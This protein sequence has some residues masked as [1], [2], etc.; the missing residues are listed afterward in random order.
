[1]GQRGGQYGAI[2]PFPVGDASVQDNNRNTIFVPVTQG[3]LEGGF[4]DDNTTPFVTFAEIDLD[5]TIQ[6]GVSFFPIT[7]YRL[8]GI[9][10]RFKLRRNAD[11]SLS[12]LR[13]NEVY[14]TPEELPSD[15]DASTRNAMLEPTYTTVNINS[16]EVNYNAMD[17]NLNT[18]NEVIVKLN[19]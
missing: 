17:L 1:M 2:L 18:V 11:T 19:Q 13:K 8:T 12:W 9:F 15:V 10:D 14:T 4:G 6:G 3:P 7:K 5:D 16:L